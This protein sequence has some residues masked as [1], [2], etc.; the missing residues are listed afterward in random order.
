MELGCEG[1]TICGLDKAPTRLEKVREFKTC[2]K[3]RVLFMT[4]NTGGEGMNLVEANHVIMLDLWWHAQTVVQAIARCYRSGQ[5]RT[6]HM[7]ALLVDNTVEDYMS[8]TCMR[9]VSDISHFN[10]YEEEHPLYST[11]LQKEMER[12]K[13]EEDK[14]SNGTI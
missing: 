4:Y 9:K 3:K 5:T 10:G 6:V 8:S 12:A 7:Y 11:L 1:T 14:E 13:L 2:P